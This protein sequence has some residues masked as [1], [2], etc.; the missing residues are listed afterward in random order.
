MN[1]F[2]E[3]AELGYTD[4]GGTLISGDGGEVRCCDVSFL[5]R[6]YD[7]SVCVRLCE[8]IERL[9]APKGS[10]LQIYRSD[11]EDEDAVPEIIPVGTKE[12]MAIYLNGTDLP[13]EVYKDC[14]INFVIER[15]DNMMDGGGRYMSCW[16]GPTETA[17]YCYGDSFEAMR[18]KE[19]REA[20]A[21]CF[22]G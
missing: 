15:I 3:K 2:L 14:D 7:E 1:E 22:V 8:M 12:G 21:A 20:I 10:V 6:H 5:I 16:Q 11:G 4:G 18:E 17:L 13:D 9:G 19:R